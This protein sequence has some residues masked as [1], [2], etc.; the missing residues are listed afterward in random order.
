MKECKGSLK[1]KITFR[2][3]HFGSINGKNTKR[4]VSAFLFV[5]YLAGIMLF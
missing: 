1:R 4:N 3:L 5:K 2:R